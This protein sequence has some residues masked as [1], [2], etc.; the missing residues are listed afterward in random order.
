MTWPETTQ[1]NL[2]I[3]C[4]IMCCYS[5][6]EKTNPDP[7][8][9]HRSSDYGVANT[10]MNNALSRTPW[11]DMH[12]TCLWRSSIPLLHV[13]TVDGQPEPGLEPG[14]VAAGSCPGYQSDLLKVRASR[15]L[16]LSFCNNLIINC[17]S[18]CWCNICI[19]SWIFQENI[20]V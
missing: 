13:N 1:C 16:F 19:S 4:Y 9:H 5:V 11:R 7:Y 12:L 18:P 8:F 15:F 20:C 17:H 2:E 6:Q 10:A 14:S 3:W